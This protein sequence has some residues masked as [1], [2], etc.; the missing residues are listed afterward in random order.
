MLADRRHQPSADGAVTK[1]CEITFED[2]ISRHDDAMIAMMLLENDPM[3][4]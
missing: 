1:V 3:M 4:R 2:R